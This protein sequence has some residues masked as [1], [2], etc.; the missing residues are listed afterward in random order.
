MEPVTEAEM[1]QTADA[2]RDT[3]RIYFPGKCYE[4]NSAPRIDKGLKR[5]RLK[6]D[7]LAEFN[8]TRRAKLQSHP[9]VKD[10]RSV[11]DLADRHIRL[12]GSWTPKMQKEHEFQVQKIVR[13]AG[14]AWKSGGVLESERSDFQA[15]GREHQARRAKTIHNRMLADS[16]KYSRKLPTR[17]LDFSLGGGVFF[18]PGC[19]DGF[20]GDA[21]ISDAVVNQTIRSNHMQ[22]V[23]DPI[24]AA[25]GYIVVALPKK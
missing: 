10:L 15:V 6:T 23:D 25:A 2:T 17:P 24:D 5:R 22:R 11:Q 12:A 18:E 8:R 21:E 3:W 19:L 13:G 7:S 9:G 20:Q 16:R 14:E 4:P 1:R